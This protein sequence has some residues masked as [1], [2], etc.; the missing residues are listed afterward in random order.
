MPPEA[1]VEQRCERREADHAATKTKLIRTQ[2]PIGLA[3]RLR[4]LLALLCHLGGVVEEQ[5]SPIANDVVHEEEWLIAIRM[6]FNVVAIC[7]DNATQE[8]A[9]GQVTEQWRTLQYEQHSRSERVAG[10]VRGLAQVSKQ[11]F[12]RV[13]LQKRAPLRRLGK[14]DVILGSC[15]GQPNLMAVEVRCGTRHARD[16]EI[17]VALLGHLFATA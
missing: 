11:T 12:S 5:A 6:R 3:F 8:L 9:V 15:D 13:Y 4:E 17:D 1:V 7:V 14:T 16:K 10:V 2:T